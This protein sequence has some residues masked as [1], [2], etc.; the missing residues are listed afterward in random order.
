MKQAN[1]TFAVPEKRKA[2]LKSEQRIQELEAMKQEMDRYVNNLDEQL[3][4]NRI[5]KRKHNKFL[6]E[7]FNGKT[8]EQLQQEINA[9]IEKLEQVIKHKKTKREV[10]ISATIILIFALIGLFMQYPLEGITGFAVGTTETTETLVYDR[11]FEAYT[12]TTLKLADV[13]SLKISGV[14][15]GTGALVKLRIGEVEYIIADIKPPEQDNLI[16]GLVVGEEEPIEEG[17]AYV[18]TTDKIEYELGETVYI[19]LEPDSD[20]KSI[21][22]E[23]GEETHKLEGDSYVTENL[24][25]HQVIALVVLPDDILR[26]ETDFVVNAVSEIATNE[27]NTSVNETETNTTE[28]EINETI[29][30]TVNETETNQ[31]NNTANATTETG[32]A[33]DNL[34][35]E[36]CNLAEISNPVLI[37]ELEE[38]SSLTITEL[39]L[40]QTTDNN[41]PKQEQAIPDITLGIG[42]IH[43]INLDEYFTEP[44]GETIHYDINEIAEISANIIGNELSISSENIGTYTAFVYATDGDKLTTSNTFEIIIQEEEVVQPVIEET[45]ET[46]EVISDPCSHPD[47]NQRPIECIEGKESEYFV[48]ESVF[49]TDGRRGNT[50][51]ITALGNLMIKGELHENAVI[52]PSANDFKVTTI[53][54]DYEDIPVAWIDSD[55]GN[56]YLKGALYEEDFFLTPTPNAFVIQNKRNINLAYVDRRTGDLHIK[57]NLVQNRE[58]IE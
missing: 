53:N 41:A 21:Y 42:Q 43:S 16:T 30:E 38:G 39:I 24:G 17:P 33:F 10:S 48:L 4:D 36:T 45:P 29:N 34:C 56:L 6:K 40:T 55:T 18:L 37:V 31:T 7:E 57:G 19:F 54:S 25:A 11:V 5:S 50:A 8:K 47:P 13:T 51:R 23:F 14:L 20:N 2:F 12:E 46:P 58:T 22:V 1:G 28:P 26:L 9:E 49:L 15:Q 3:M 27:T 32:Y 52:N 35:L 44:D